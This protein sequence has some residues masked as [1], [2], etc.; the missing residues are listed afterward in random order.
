MRIAYL[1][2]PYPPMVSGASIV[3]EQLANEMANRGHEVL[4]IAASDNGKQYFVQK[5][6]LT[7]LR[8]K[9]IQNPLRVNQRSIFF[10]KKAILRALKEFQPDLIHAHEPLQIGLY[11]I[12]FAKQTKIPILLT[13][14][15][16]PW[17]V[18]SYF[19]NRF[20]IRMLIEKIIWK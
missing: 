16:L 12:K 10:Q 14:H 19:P 11:G 5:K 17:F 9:S 6:N 15:Q 4:V 20:K 13:T 7:V 18:A 2:Q 1:T 3:V 8:L